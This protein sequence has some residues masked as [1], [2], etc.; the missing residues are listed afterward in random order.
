MF[1]TKIKI[2]A[3][4]ILAATSFFFAF[5]S[6][7]VDSK[8]TTFKT[9]KS[10]PVEL[11]KVVWERNFDKGL[12]KA[13]S[14]DKPIFLLFQEVPGC[15]TCRNY[16]NDVLSHPQIVE[17]IET[18]FVPVA[19][20]NN[21]KGKD[22]EVLKFYNEP[23]WNNPVVRIVDFN[24]K[25][26]INRVSGNYSK[27]GIVHAMATAL[28]TEGKEIP[29]YLNL[30]KQNLEAAVTGT[31]TATFS[32]Y[33]FWTGEKKLGQVDGVLETQAG[34]MSGRE[35]VEVK[36]NPILISYE[37]L[38]QAAKDASCASHVYTENSTQTEAAQKVVGN[39]K[40]SQKSKFRLDKDP[41]YYLSRTIY[42]F[43][44][45]T[46]TQAVKVNAKIGS[47]QSPDEFLS[48][49]QLELLSFIKKHPNKKWNNMINVDFVK[50]WEK[51]EK[52]RA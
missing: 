19:I 30:L 13:Q 27:L 34:W 5:K 44:P 22:A 51:V 20:F 1:S 33:C 29:T 7:Q 38:V 41:K 39:N 12:A 50:G 47:G 46:P 3:L 10:Q 6:N 35:V 52:E 4:L 8:K 2:T 21:K 11:G 18:L 37:N 45:M 48:P 36:Y 15:A 17:A 24:R 40:A 25:N 31:E 49:R 43:L 28:H 16:G 9:V 26:I 32:M 42:R 23:S 14:E